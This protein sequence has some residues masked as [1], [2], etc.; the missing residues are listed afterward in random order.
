[1]KKSTLFSAAFAAVAGFFT[2]AE[3]AFAAGFSWNNSWTQPEISSKQVTGFND[4]PFQPFVPRESIELPNSGQFELDPRKLFLT[5][6]NDVSV[7]FV[8]EAAVYSN[9]LAYQATGT[10]NKSGLV[11]NDVSCNGQGCLQPESD[12]PLRVG[13]GVKLGKLPAG[14]QLDFWLRADGARRG[15]NTNIFGTESPLNS[16]FLQHVVAYAVDDYLLVG[17]EDLYGAKGAT[18]VDP[19]TGRSN[20]NS[21]RDFNDVVFAIDIGR[22]NLDELKNP[23]KVPEPSAMLSLVGVAAVGMFKLRRTLT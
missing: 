18:G 8:N 7:Y 20:E 14:T 1:M 3:S 16:D 6:E 23:R 2:V 5:F 9:Q 4:A 15:N 12:G 22:K 21:D 17:F 19:R 10:S 11:F 13:D